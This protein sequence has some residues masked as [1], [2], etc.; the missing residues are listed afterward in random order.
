MRLQLTI[1]LL[2]YACATCGCAPTKQATSKQPMSPEALKRL[3]E[4]AEYEMSRGDNPSLRFRANLQELCEIPYDRATLPLL[5][6]DGR[7]IATVIGPTP[8]MALGP[9]PGPAE[10]GTR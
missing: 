6:P 10:G 9:G 2:L 7:F 8:G 3:N 1:L 4:I 5:S